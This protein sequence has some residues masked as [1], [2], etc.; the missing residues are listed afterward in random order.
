M[1]LQNHEFWLPRRALPTIAMQLLLLPALTPSL[2]WSIPL[3]TLITSVVA[4]SSH[5]KTLP[6]IRLNRRWIN[7]LVLVSFG[8]W[9]SAFPSKLTLEP[10]V[11]LLLLG[12][13]LKL[14]EV[15][16]PRDAYVLIFSN[17]ALLASLFLFDQ[18]LWA[19]I[20]ALVV[21]WLALAALVEINKTVDEPKSLTRKV[22]FPMAIVVGAIPMTLVWFLIFP[23]VAP[24][25][26][27]PVLGESVK[28]GMSD[29]LRPG[30]VADLGRDAS[31]AFRVEFTGDMPNY[32]ELYWRGITLGAFDNGSWRQHNHLKEPRNASFARRLS[33]TKSN[34]SDAVGTY[35]VFQTA[36]QRSWLY[37]LNP[38]ATS[39]DHAKPLLDNTY[40]T[41]WPITSD[42]ETSY[43]LLNVTAGKTPPTGS[44][45]EQAL[46]ALEMVFPR[47][48][49][50]RSLALAQQLMVPGNSQE[51]VLRTLNWFRTQ[52]LIYT[53]QPDLISESNF[54]D[55]FLFET[56][57]GFCEHFAYSFV[58]LMRL[59]EIPARI[60]GGYMG[61]EINPLNGTVTV[62]ELDAHA[63]AEVWLDDLGW[64][65]VDPTATVAPDRIEQG[66]LESLQGTPGFLSSSPL[67]L[68][69]LRDW[70]WV[71]QM[72]LELDAINYRWQSGVMSYQQA[73]QSELLTNLL[74]QITASKI[75]A[76]LALGL[77]L[78]LLPVA[79]LVGLHRYKH[80]R[81]PKYR[82]YRRLARTLSV[83][84]IERQRGET[85][86]Q[87]SQ[88]ALLIPNIDVTLI[89]DQLADFE[90]IWYGATE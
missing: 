19:T 73:Q 77:G 68:L 89:E 18:S 62:R 87:A 21:L 1:S 57:S 5:Q 30:D 59:M 64:V 79:L 8:V 31:V 41:R 84:G 36:S 32:S 7:T 58:V 20:T 38:S 44:V 69:R 61:G 80:W 27:I 22:I 67:S 60:V 35:K 16:A 55:R 63:W 51:S 14:I 25:W 46:L 54:V 53:L 33:T 90:K 88:R 39:D 75:L 83:H 9:W 72:R 28:M 40:Q 85:L 70:H 12:A 17:I 49:N 82:A 6:V 37:Q 45:N 56:Q 66:S 23:R 47:D 81:Q 10:A 86:R 78:S 42:L 26:A 71:N 11:G 48:L 52:P 65:R 4:L 50:P 29:T 15:R 13:S 3:L 2:G 24:L 76:V 34:T 74:G 43:T